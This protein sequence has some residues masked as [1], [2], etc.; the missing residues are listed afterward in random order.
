[1]TRFLIFSGY[2]ERAIVALCRELAS[3]GRPFSIIAAGDRDP[4]FRTAYRS[5]V[6]AIRAVTALD[7]A[8]LDRCIRRTQAAHPGDRWVIAPTSEFL[9]HHVL[10]H[11]EWFASRRCEIPLVDASCYARVTNKA[12]FRALCEQAGIAV[13][14]LVDFQG[15]PGAGAY[16]FVAKPRANVSTDGRSLYPA[17]IH[18]ADEWTRQRDALG[19]LDDYYFET[20]IDGSS[21]YLLYYLPAD[22]SAPAFRWSQRNLLQQPNGKSMVLAVSD[23]LHLAPISDRVINML[24]GTGFH[25]LAMVEVIRHHDDYVAIEL[26][27]RLWGPLQ[28]LRNSG[29]HLIR[30]FVEDALDGRITSADPRAG[31]AASY[32]WL[33][34]LQPGMTWH[35]RPPRYPWLWLTPR[36]VGDVYLRR[37][38]VGLFIDECVRRAA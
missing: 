8:D 38:T 13:P 4:I 7:A 25:G 27:P 12:S 11:R 32:L 30:A 6:A 37:D 2:N 14:P 15:D 34:G 22:A 33:G 3:M 20:L 18:S 28:L 17:L 35:C 9:N 29:S 1:M 23:D 16:P 10:A 31:H 5:N 26:N 21:H 19:S 36:L 24:R